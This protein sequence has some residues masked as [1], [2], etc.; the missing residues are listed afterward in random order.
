[1]LRDYA[2]SAKRLQPKGERRSSR[3][4]LDDVVERRRGTA[5]P[6]HLKRPLPRASNGGMAYLTDAEE[7]QRV[8]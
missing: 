3:F 5:L 4:E 7:E 8:A 2:I 6:F 1:M